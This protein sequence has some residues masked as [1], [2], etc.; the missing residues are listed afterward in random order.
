MQNIRQKVY[1]WLRGSEGFFKTDMVYL[2]KG[3]FWLTLGQVVA[4]ISSF[5]LAIA[6]ANLLPRE[7]YGTY[8]YILAIGG[9]LTVFTLTGMGTAVTQ[10]VARGL[11]NVLLPAFKAR[12]QWGLVGTL[13]SFTGSAYYY[14]NDNITLSLGL[15]IIGIFMPVMEASVLYDSV[16]HGKK[17]FDLTTKYFVVGQLTSVS[18]SILALFFTTNV[19]VLVFIYFASWTFLRIIF[20]KRTLPQVSAEGED[21]PATL[22]Y[23]KHLSLM[24]VIGVVANYA[25]RIL[26]FHYVGAVEAAIYS[27]AIAIPEQIKGVFKN[28][29]NLALPKFSE[30]PEEDIQKSLWGKMGKMAIVLLMVIVLYIFAA[31]Y[32]FRILFP[33]Y[34]DSIFYS[35]IFITSLITAVSILPLSY[36]QGQARKKE[37]YIFN[38]ATPVIQLVLLFCGAYFYG[39]LGVVFARVASRFINSAIIIL[40]SRN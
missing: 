37:L 16:W 13:V 18:L 14:L 17:R 32:V 8:K 29:G 35:Q 34:L 5:L 22:S 26:V 2:A 4:S 21:A 36:L 33:Q 3:G 1:Q 27:I 7:V 6:F 31:P 23:G 12:L 40:L 9:T 25:D 15:L 30:R 28:V 19:L 10:A 11:D 38:T 20:F 24:G 39:V